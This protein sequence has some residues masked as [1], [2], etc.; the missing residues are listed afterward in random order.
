[1]L[2]KSRTNHGC[3]DII[4]PLVAPRLSVNPF[5]SIIKHSISMHQASRGPASITRCASEEGPAESGTCH[6]LLSRHAM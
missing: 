6:H 5:F 2:S 1:M 4:T 3:Q